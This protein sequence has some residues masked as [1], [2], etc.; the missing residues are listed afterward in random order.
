LDRT[1]LIVDDIYL[2]RHVLARSLQNAGYRVLEAENGRQAI[3][4]LENN[5]VCCIFMDIEM[6]VMNGIETVRYIRSQMPH[7]KSSV[8]VFALTAYN[9]STVGDY[10]DLSYFD[11]VITKPFSM[12]Q[13]EKILSQA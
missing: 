5:E 11:G 9:H 8:K 4:M 10:L 13:I 3:E 1:V 2:N 12:Q 6:P 7:A